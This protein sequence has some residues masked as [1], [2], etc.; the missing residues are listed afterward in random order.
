MARHRA[1]EFR[2]FLD[3]IEKNVQTDVDV[4]VVMDNVSS[5]KT[6]P[7]RDW[8]LGGRLGMLAT[9]QPQHPGSITSSIFLHC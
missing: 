8:V 5:Y 1:T 4:H 3:R 6:Q 7:I 9:Q 2:P